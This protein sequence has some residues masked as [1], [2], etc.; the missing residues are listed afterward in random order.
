[1]STTVTRKID[2]LNAEIAQVQ[3]AAGKL[4]TRLAQRAAYASPEEYQEIRELMAALKALGT[5]S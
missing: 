2:R 3:L 5:S 4:V 1:V